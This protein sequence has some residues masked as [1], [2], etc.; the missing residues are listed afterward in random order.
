MCQDAIDDAT[1]TKTEKLLEFKSEYGKEMADIA[2]PKIE[3][4]CAPGKKPKPDTEKAYKMGKDDYYAQ[5][6]LAGKKNPNSTWWGQKPQRKRKL[7]TIERRAQKK[8]K[9]AAEGEAAPR[10]TVAPA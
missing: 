6:Q 1:E 4:A 8:S 3:V 7:E 10:D 9:A 2:W 5:M